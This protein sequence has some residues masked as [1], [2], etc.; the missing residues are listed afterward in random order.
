M[1]LGNAEF[2]E[3]SFFSEGFDSEEKTD[4][5]LSCEISCNYHLDRIRFVLCILR[6][7]SFIILPDRT[8]GLCAS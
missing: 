6:Y 5:F 2:P 3:L 7:S 8:E 1:A 4:L